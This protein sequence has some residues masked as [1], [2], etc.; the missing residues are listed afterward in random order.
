[1]KKQTSLQA[2]K[3]SKKELKTIAGGMLNCM[4]PGN[5]CEGPNC[6]P[7]IVSDDPRAYCTIISPRC[8]Q[9]VCRP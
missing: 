9:I 8:G 1:M 7:P 5:P 3:L 4:Q 6:D 2:K